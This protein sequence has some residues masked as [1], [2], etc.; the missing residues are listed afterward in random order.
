[1]EQLSPRLG[2][3]VPLPQLVQV[4]PQSAGQF[5]QLSPQACSQVPLPQLAMKVDELPW[6]TKPVRLG[7]HWPSFTQIAPDWQVFA[8][9]PQSWPQDA[10][11][12][13]QSQV[14]LPQEEPGVPPGPQMM[15]E[16][17]GMHC[18]GA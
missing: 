12:S 11:V 10:W 5:T 8:R 9:Q 18:P 2:S 1:V 7:S 13:P 16:R 4:P 3:Q 17:P 14:P 15:P 6:Q